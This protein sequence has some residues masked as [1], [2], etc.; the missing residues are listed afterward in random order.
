MNTPVIRAKVVCSQLA[1]TASAQEIVHFFAAC[2]GSDE[3]KQF[4]KF[5]PS[6]SLAITIDNPGA[7]NVFAPCAEYYLDFIPVK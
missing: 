5:T 7:Q 4:S 3:N 1:K 2:G 6:L